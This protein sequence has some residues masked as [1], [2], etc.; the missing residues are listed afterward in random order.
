MKNMS[1]LRRFPELTIFGAGSY[2]RLEASQ[3]SDI[4]MFFLNASS[5]ADLLEP[6]TSQLRLFARVIDIV[7]KMDFPKFSNDGEYLKI[8]HMGDMVEQLGGRK[9]DYDN[10]FTTR[11]LLLLESQYLC[12]PDL[13][14]KAISRI[15]QSYFRD[16]PRHRSDFK[17]IFL[18][19]DIMRYWK[20]LCLNY[21]NKRL[22]KTSDKYAVVTRRVRNFKLKI[23]RMT[24]CFATIA[25]LGC[26]MKAISEQVVEEIVRLTPR[27]RLLSIPEH[28]SESKAT[29]DEILLLY[30]WFLEMTALSTN[31]LERHFTDQKKREKAFRR[32][33]DFGNKMFEL[34]K[35]VDKKHRI[36]RY[37]VI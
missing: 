25:L 34:L 5:E 6:R 12:R 24:T 3:H 22:R 14:N 21:E 7:G 36:L 35:I 10:H 28:L 29:I 13:Y 32:A 23:S 17:P 9:D 26:R 8:L 19:N 30:G 18:V 33:N 16:Y 20:T 11:M 1:E 37:L 15:I 31:Q 27:Q 4:D 2:A